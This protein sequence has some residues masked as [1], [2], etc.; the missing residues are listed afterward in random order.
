MAPNNKGKLQHF[1]CPLHMYCRLRDL[2]LSKKKARK[3]CNWY[4]VNIYKLI[5]KRVLKT[6]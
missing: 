4:E 3:L 6:I 2:G 5:Y 1:L